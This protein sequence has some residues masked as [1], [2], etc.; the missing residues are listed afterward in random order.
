MKPSHMLYGGT[1]ISLYA[2]NLRIESVLRTLPDEPF[3]TA[4]RDEKLL[5]RCIET[6]TSA[7]LANVTMVVY[8]MDK[9]RRMALVFTVNEDI[10]AKGTEELHLFRIQG[11]RDY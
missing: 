11:R 2:L 5:P 8:L 9:K 4:S 3:S 6:F 7:S 10:G 1:H